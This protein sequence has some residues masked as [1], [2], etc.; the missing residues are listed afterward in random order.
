[1]FVPRGSRPV[2]NVRAMYGSFC[3]GNARLRATVTYINDL[4][5]ICL[6]VQSNVIERHER[7]LAAQVDLPPLAHERDLVI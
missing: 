1:M 6:L 7:N 3:S 4:N 5:S 2:A